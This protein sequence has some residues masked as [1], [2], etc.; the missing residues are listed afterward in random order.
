MTNYDSQDA[1]RYTNEYL[2]QEYR[3]QAAGAN[4]K[5]EKLQK[6]NED[7]KNENLTSRQTV[8]IINET[9]VLVQNK[10]LLSNLISFLIFFITSILIISK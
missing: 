7:L 8:M 9:N 10:S 1:T 5:L 4:Y 2:A 6:E 3:N